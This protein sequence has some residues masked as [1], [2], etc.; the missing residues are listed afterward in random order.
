VIGVVTSVVSA[1]YY[2]RVVKVM[3]FDEPVPAFDRPLSVELK[4]VLVVTAIIT[5][6]FFALPGP[7]IGVASAAAASLFAR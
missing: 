4:S 5:L 1:F 3:Y 2:F 6:F 7:L